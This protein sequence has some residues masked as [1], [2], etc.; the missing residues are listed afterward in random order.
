MTYRQAIILLLSLTLCVKAAT[1]QKPFA[2]GMLVYNVKLTSAD[3]VSFSGVYTFLIKDG[4]IKKELKLDNGYHDV[5]LIN[6]KKNSVYT[7]QSGNGKNYAIQ[8]S[9]DDLLQTQ[10]KFKG[11]SITDEQN[12]SKQ[13][14]GFDIYRGVVIYRDSVRSEILYATEWRPAQSVMFNRFPGAQFM[15]IRFSYKEESG[16]SMI[17]EAVKVEPGPVASSVFRI[18]A[19]YKMI[20]YEEYKQLSKE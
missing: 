2:E 11:F 15:P 8:L 7:L 19:D 18:P 14:S 13:L 12:T 1:A 10:E 5:T 9:M 6:C 20:S 4:E 16:I 3:N 17:F